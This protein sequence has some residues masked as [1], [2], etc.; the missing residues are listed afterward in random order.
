VGNVDWSEFTVAQCPGEFASIN[1]IGL[2]CSFFMDGRDV[3]RVDHD[4]I[5]TERF[6]V[7]VDPEAAV[8]C[9]VGTVILSAREVT[10]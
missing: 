8:A 3:C 9:F 4:T 10:V 1:A 5:N 6:E 2:E 7:I